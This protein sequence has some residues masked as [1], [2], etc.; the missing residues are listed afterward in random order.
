[1]TGRRTDM[2]RRT[3]ALIGLRGSGKTTVGRILAELLDGECIDV[4]DDGVYVRDL[5]RF[6]VVSSM[7][8]SDFKKHNPTGPVLSMALQ[9][10]LQQK[11]QW[12]EPIKLVVPHRIR[13]WIKQK[14]YRMNRADGVP[15]PRLPDETRM[16]LWARFESEVILLEQLLGRSLR[17]V[18]GPETTSRRSANVAVTKRG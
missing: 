4:D 18:W 11:R 13:R 5:Y 8:K 12:K 10:S 16:K 7:F 9:D 17:N 14:I 2:L 3:I 15:L 1:M 6:L